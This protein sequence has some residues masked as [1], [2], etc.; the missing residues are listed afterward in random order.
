MTRVTFFYPNDSLEIF[1]FVRNIENH[2]AAGLDGLTAE[3]LKVSLDVICDSL[4]YLINQSLSSDV[5]PKFLK[6]AKMVPIIRSG[7]KA[8]VRIMDPYHIYRF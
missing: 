5:F 8:I 2:N 3:S 7:E 4:T 6:T 1:K